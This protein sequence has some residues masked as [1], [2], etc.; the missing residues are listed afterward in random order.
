M[1]NEQTRQ[2]VEI[3]CKD[4]ND[5][6]KLIFPECMA[7]AKIYKCLGESLTVDFVNVPDRSH[8]P[9]GIIHNVN[10]HMKFMCHID[11][12]TTHS[13]N[14]GDTFEMEL[15]TWYGSLCKQHG[16]KYRKIKAKSP[17][18]LLKKL[19]EWFKKNKDI[20]DAIEGK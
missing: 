13:L 9:N 16:L 18:E 3:A 6:I 4:F 7:I 2:D 20:I 17:S 11:T 12:S 14:I 19:L 10:S 5:Q 1:M 15:L 8:F